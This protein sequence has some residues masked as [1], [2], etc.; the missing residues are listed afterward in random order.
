MFGKV[1]NPKNEKLPDLNLREFATFVPLIILAVWIGLYPT[2][3]LDWLDTS[4]N[5]VVARV[6]P[7]YSGRRPRS[8]RTAPENVAANTFVLAG[9]R[10]AGEA[11]EPRQ[12]LSPGSPRRR[13]AGGQLGA[14]AGGPATALKPTGGQ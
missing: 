14:A 10:A 1:E 8:R 3:F 11:A 4:V 2:P 6:S 13:R 9:V 7:Q 5:A 12:R